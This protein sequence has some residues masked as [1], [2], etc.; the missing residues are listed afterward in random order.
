MAFH[1]GVLSV[2]PGEDGGVLG[3]EARVREAESADND[4]HL[5]VFGVGRDSGGACQASHSEGAHVQS[6][7]QPR[8]EAP[9]ATTST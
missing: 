8:K 6:D 5:L 1:V 2:V 9:A 4:T 7:F 3:Q